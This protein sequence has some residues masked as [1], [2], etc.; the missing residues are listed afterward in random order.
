MPIFPLAPFSYSSRRTEISQVITAAETTRSRDI[1]GYADLNLSV[2]N[3]LSVTLHAQNDSRF[4]VA[5]ELRCNKVS[6][7]GLNIV[8]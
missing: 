4:S 6:L 3:A 8:V 5:R 1:V 7:K 2:Q